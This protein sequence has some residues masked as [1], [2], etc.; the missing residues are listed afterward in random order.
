MLL[1]IKYITSALFITLLGSS[2]VI[3]QIT[4]T[5][6]DCYG[7]AFCSDTPIEVILNHKNNQ[8]F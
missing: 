1:P 2:A 5:Q 8:S 6:Q 7:P 3:G 4:K